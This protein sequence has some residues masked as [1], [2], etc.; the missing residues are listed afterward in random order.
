MARS[1]LDDRLG[2][3]RLARELRLGDY[4]YDKNSEFRLDGMAVSRVGK[5]EVVDGRISQYQQKEQAR[6]GLAFAQRATETPES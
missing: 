6:S 4:I 1:K 3:F 2:G 5:N